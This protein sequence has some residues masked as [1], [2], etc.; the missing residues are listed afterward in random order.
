MNVEQLMSRPV[1]C[2]TAQ[3]SLARAAEL[4]WEFDCGLVPVVADEG[5]A[6][7][8]GVITDRD[9]CMNAMF[10]GRPLNELRVAEAMARDVRFCRPADSLADAERVMSESQIRRLPVVAEDGTLVGMITLADLAEEAAR[11]LP[12]SRQSISETEVGDTL[13]AICRPPHRELAA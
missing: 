13:A 5:A 2:C 3:D 8:A 7:L 12:A 10:A 6:Q 1:H 9:I 11:E 4:M